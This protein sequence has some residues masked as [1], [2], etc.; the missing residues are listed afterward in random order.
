MSQQLVM[1]V[2]NTPRVA[3]FGKLPGLGDF[4][5]R[6]M[7]H[8]FGSD[9]DHWLRSGLEQ[10]RNEAPHD[11][12]QR[13]VQSPLW[14]FVAPARATGKPT[15]GVVAPSIDRVGRYYPITILAIAN[16]VD[17]VFASDMDLSLFFTAARNVVIDA[18]RLPMSADGLDSRLSDLVWPFLEKAE[19]L[20]TSLFSDLLA[21]L[22]AASDLSSQ[23]TEVT[24][25]SLP[26]RDFLVKGSG[27][28]VWWVPPT[29]KE[30][31]QEVVHHGELYSSLFSR[32]FKGDGR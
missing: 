24:L 14:C 27:T 13:F 3:W 22:N 11:W 31:Y 5:G 4:V 2:L 9:W 32:L 1:S 16:E 26:W 28:S 19:T 29:A 7:P 8:A 17:A 6:R 25:P 15:C 21:D 10:L 30:P 23:S 20:K 18:R 12:E